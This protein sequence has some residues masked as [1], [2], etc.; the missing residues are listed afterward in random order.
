[1]T[2]LDALI[3]TAG[4]AEKLERLLNTFPAPELE[5]VFAQLKDSGHL[6]IMLD[7]VGAET[8]AGMIRQWMAKGKF[9][10]LNQFME[11]LA[12]GVGKELAE[13]AALSGKS[14]VIDSNTAIALMK[15]ADPALRA[16]MNAGEK[17]RVAY[18]KSLPAGTELRAVNVTIGEV[19]SG[20][21]NLKGVP[22]EVA[23]NRPVTRKCSAR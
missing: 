9:D 14:L 2:K 1:M 16:T 13:T 22:I 7:H 23:R 8:G 17:A 3:A 4:D 19:G 18:I 5:T 12:G 10:K 15:D 11:R 6:A 21:V 20:V